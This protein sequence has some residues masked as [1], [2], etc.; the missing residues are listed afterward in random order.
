MGGQGFIGELGV[1]GHLPYINSGPGRR[2]VDRRP[3]TDDWPAK[4]PTR[5]REPHRNKGHNTVQCSSVQ[6]SA[7]HTMGKFCNK[8]VHNVRPVAVC[9]SAGWFSITVMAG[10][11]GQ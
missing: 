4:S 1:S 2:S 10:I 7:V 5:N 9:G 8:F 6:C 11:A 3:E